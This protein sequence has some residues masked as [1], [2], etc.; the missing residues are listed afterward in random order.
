MNHE[1]E[2]TDGVRLTIKSLEWSEKSIFNDMNKVKPVVVNDVLHLENITAKQYLD[3]YHRLR[4]ECWVLNLLN[5]GFDHLTSL[6]DAADYVGYE[7][8]YEELLQLRDTVRPD[9]VQKKIDP[10]AEFQG[11]CICF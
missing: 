3:L 6:L 1:V 5:L 10:Y 11:S 9:H 7:Q 2:T 8:A 4:C